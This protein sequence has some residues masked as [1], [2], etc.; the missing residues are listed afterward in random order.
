VAKLRCESTIAIARTPAEI[1]PWLLDTEKVP[2]WVTGLEVYRRLDDGPL[3]IGVRIHQE[4]VVSGHRLT[5]EM[6]LTRLDPPLAADQRF[7]GSGYRAVNQYRIVAD[8]GASRVTWAMGGETTSFSAR[9]MAPMV[10]SRLQDKLDV[11]LG[12]LRTLLEDGP[13]PA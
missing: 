1:F 10:Q 4:V 11:D 12:R 13:E 8:G 6:E 7:S 5:F 2:R 3:R 9:M